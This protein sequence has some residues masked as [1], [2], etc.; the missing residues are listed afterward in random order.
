[1]NEL[2]FVFYLCY[3]T[4]V[5]KNIKHSQNFTLKM[6][7]RRGKMKKK[8]IIA[9][10]VT[11][12]LVFAMVLAPVQGASLSEQLADSQAKQ[13]SARLVIDTTKNTI[14]GIEEEIN[15]VNVEVEKIN[16]EIGTLDSEI[17]TLEEKIAKT[18]EEIGVAEAKKVEQ[19]GAMNERVRSMYMM[20]NTSIV[21]FLFSSTS[22]SDLFTKLDMSRHIVAADKESLSAIEGTKKEIETKKKEIEGDRLKIVDKRNTQQTALADQKSIIAQKDELVAK[23]QNVVAEYTA[24]EQAEAAEAVNISGQIAAYYAEQQRLAEE[25]AAQDAANKEKAAQ[26][27]ANKENASG[28]ESAGGGESSGGGEAS[29]GGESSGGGEASGGGGSAEPPSFSGSIVWPCGGEITDSFGWRICPFHGSEYHSG[30]DIGASSGTPIAAAGN[31][32]VISSGWNGE[33]GN[34]VIID[35]GNGVS[36]LYAHMSSTAVSAG[37]SVSAGQTLGY[38]GSTGAST[39][40][41][42]HFEMAV[43]G[44]VVDPMSY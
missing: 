15:K 11:G 29:G 39:G 21:E 41:H 25:K 36:A 32:T 38:V 7:R 30:V 22:F 18:Q 19:E 28:G 8:K 27:A 37:Q 9:G 20:G 3:N 24:I 23:N 13:A 6:R 12:S 17:N 44:S 35:L 10:I 42:L 31:A 43:Y 40:A 2:H 4:I 16:A 34:C 5:T 1:M 26:D 14:Q 33:Y